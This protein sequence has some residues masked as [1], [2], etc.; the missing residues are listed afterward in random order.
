MTDPISRYEQLRQEEERIAKEI[1]SL[2]EDDAFKKD[3][4]CKQDIE[5]FLQ[6]Y[7]KTPKDLLRLFPE[8]LPDASSPKRTRTKKQSKTRRPL[9]RYTNPDT[10]E[11]VEVE[12]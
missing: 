10:G 8:I 3:M 5:Q 6:E 7:G 1:A 2:Q 12:G 11:T 4:A 9:K